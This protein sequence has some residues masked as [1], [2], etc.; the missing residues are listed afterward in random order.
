MPVAKLLLLIRFYVVR[1]LLVELFAMLLSLSTDILC[2]NILCN[3][4]NMYGSLSDLDIL[5][6]AYYYYYYALC[7]MYVLISLMNWP[8]TGLGNWPVG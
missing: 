6:F 5:C 4:Y 3:K 1:R 2:Y 7:I 8:V